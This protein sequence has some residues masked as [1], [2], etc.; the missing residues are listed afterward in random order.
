LYTGWYTTDYEGNELLQ[1]WCTNYAATLFLLDLFLE[2]VL[3]INTLCVI[4]YIIVMNNNLRLLCAA[5]ETGLL[6]HLVDVWISL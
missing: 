4:Q 3:T 6:W 1:N 5:Y 2:Q